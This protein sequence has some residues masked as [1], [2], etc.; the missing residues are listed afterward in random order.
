[1]FSKG[2]PP[3]SVLAAALLACACGG[4]SGGGAGAPTSPSLVQ[5]TATPAPSPTASPGGFYTFTI[6]ISPSCAG[7][8]PGEFRRRSYTTAVVVGSGIWFISS[9][10]VQF[11]AQASGSSALV[12]ALGVTEFSSTFGFEI[13]SVSG[14]GTISGTNMSGTFS[15]FISYF[16]LITGDGASCNA[17]DHQFTLTK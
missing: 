6:A 12:T 11:G 10:G 7:Q 8:F 1:M 5:P 9:S 15:G 3:R 13:V 16:S 14:R 4:G 2:S 17:G